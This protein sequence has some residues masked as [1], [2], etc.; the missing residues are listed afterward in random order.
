MVAALLQ[1]E[2]EDNSEGAGN[3]NDD[4]ESELEETVDV[5]ASNLCDSEGCINGVWLRK[6]HGLL[7]LLDEIDK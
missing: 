2:N 1:V 3:D 6:I 7:H 5:V 4:D